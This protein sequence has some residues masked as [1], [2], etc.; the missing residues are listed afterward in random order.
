[1][2]VIVPISDLVI[3]FPAVLDALNGRHQLM[4]SAWLFYKMTGNYLSV[5]LAV[6][7]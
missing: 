2:I 7:L 3:I 5:L 1:M 6:Q 4:P